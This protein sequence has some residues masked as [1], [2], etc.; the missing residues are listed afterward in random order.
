MTEYEVC[1]VVASWIRHGDVVI[2]NRD[3]PLVRANV[4]SGLENRSDK[5]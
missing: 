1:K 4:R 5:P 2:S 3:L